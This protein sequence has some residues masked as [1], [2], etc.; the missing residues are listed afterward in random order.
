MTSTTTRVD[1]R[2]R[3]TIPAALRRALGLKPGTPVVLTSD[4]PA[5]RV[6]SRGEQIFRSQQVVRRYVPAER[7]L[8]QELLAQGRGEI[9]RPRSPS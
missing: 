3:I 8:S 6:L 5:L 1:R 2:G 7:S 4:G 9:D